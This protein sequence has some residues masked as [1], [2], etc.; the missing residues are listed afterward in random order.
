MWFSE[1]RHFKL[2][3][4]YW[5][6]TISCFFHGLLFSNLRPFLGLGIRRPGP[7]GT[8]CRFYHRALAGIW[9]AS[10]ISRMPS[11]VK[12]DHSQPAVGAGLW[13]RGRGCSLTCSFNRHSRNIGLMP[14]PILAANC[15][16]GSQPGKV[17]TLLGLTS[18]GWGQETINK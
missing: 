15:K 5:S 1:R 16:A 13:G 2:Q 12:W 9:G 4:K 6:H 3:E 10:C 14:G 8:C 17:L 11:P 18:S 7:E